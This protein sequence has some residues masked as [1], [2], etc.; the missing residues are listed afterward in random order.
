MKLLSNFL[1]V[2]RYYKK[3]HLCQQ[4]YLLKDIYSRIVNCFV[5]VNFIFRLISNTAAGKKFDKH[6]III[7]GS[8]MKIMSGDI[9]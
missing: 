4:F 3:L 5:F 1:L 6:A 7:L 2:Y 8:P 9:P